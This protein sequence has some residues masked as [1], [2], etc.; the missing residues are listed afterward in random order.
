MGVDI[1]K[2]CEAYGHGLRN[3]AQRA[4]GACNQHGAAAKR[5]KGIQNISD[6]TLTSRDVMHG[7]KPL[8]SSYD[9]L[10]SGH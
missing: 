2:Y 4:R 7:V 10:P 5:Q 3:V 9:A 1:L 8:P 6:A